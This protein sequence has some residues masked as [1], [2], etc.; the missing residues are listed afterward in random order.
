MPTA[1]LLMGV[2]A[3]DAGGQI[4]Q[5][6][7]SQKASNA[8]AQEYAQQ[9]RAISTQTTAQISKQDQETGG[10]ISS[11]RAAS[12]ASGT[13][14]GGSGSIVRN[15]T[16]NRGLLS[17]AYTRYSGDLAKSQALYAAANAR[18]QGKQAFWGGI[19]GA[20]TAMG[21][22]VIGASSGQGAGSIITGLTKNFSGAAG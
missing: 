4:L 8:E 17:D 19:S 10:V 21:S 1:A 12:G 22:S 2:G 20:A 5:G 6:I 3:V 18:W 13:A 11:S 14:G 7:N 16:A 9:A 15:E